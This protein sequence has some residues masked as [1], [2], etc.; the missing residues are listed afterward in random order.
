MFTT[1]RK[2]GRN[3]IA[4]VGVLAMGLAVASSA[5]A[6][7]WTRPLDD[8]GEHEYLEMVDAIN[9]RYPTRHAPMNGSNGAN[10]YLKYSDDEYLEMI[11]AIN[12]D[13]AASR[14]VHAG[15]TYSGRSASNPYLRFDSDDAIAIMDLRREENQRHFASRPRVE[16]YSVTSTPVIITPAPQQPMGADYAHSYI[17][18]PQG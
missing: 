16:T 3:C 7:D 12:R 6:G 13:K 15:T 9:A 10:P 2:T 5:S 4:F 1:I 8:Y 14:P 11:D 18:E 17:I